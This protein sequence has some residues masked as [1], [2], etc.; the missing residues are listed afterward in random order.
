MARRS[1]KSPADPDQTPERKGNV[2]LVGLGVAAILLVTF[3]VL[4]RRTVTVDFWVHQSRAPLVVVILVAGL[5]GVV[6]T[7][8]AQRHKSRRG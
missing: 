5:L 1:S 4:N 8:L 6:V 7:A 2:R 3:A